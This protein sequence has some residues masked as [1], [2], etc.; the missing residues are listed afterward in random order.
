[1]PGA[2]RYL[3]SR[4]TVPE[5]LDRGIAVASAA[6]RRSLVAARR[7]PPT[8][9]GLEHFAKCLHHHGDVG[10]VFRVI[11]VHD[12]VG[13]V[14]HHADLRVVGVPIRGGGAICM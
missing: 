7:S 4:R 8:V 3:R 12:A 14:E 6:S 13:R 11:G 1:M 9:G 2:P 10:E 5:T